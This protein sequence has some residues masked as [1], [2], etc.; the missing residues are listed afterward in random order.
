MATYLLHLERNSFRAV[1]MQRMFRGFR[2][3]QQ[4][5]I[6][7][8]AHAELK[9]A[10]MREE[11]KEGNLSALLVPSCRQWLKVTTVRRAVT[12]SPARGL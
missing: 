3:R 6:V 11:V 12:D 8:Q 4:Y 1:A 2:V 5:Q 7:H 10:M 9:A